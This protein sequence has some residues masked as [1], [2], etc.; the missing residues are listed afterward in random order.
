MKKLNYHIERTAELNQIIRIIELLIPCFLSYD[1]SKGE[2][3][4][5]CREQDAAF[6]E[7]MLAAYV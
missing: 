5:E 3:E 4:I 6:V 7:R 2:L 1:E